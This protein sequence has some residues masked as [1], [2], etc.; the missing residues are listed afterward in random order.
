MNNLLVDY[1]FSAYGG[2][3]IRAASE[4]NITAYFQTVK[5]LFG[6]DRLEAERIL[7]CSTL[8]TPTGH[9]QFWAQR[10]GDVRPP[11]LEAACCVGMVQ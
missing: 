1:Y 11:S 5:E 3:P 8:S 10:L 4:S 6:L 2:K 7:M 9:A